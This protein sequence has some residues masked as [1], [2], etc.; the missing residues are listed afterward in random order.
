MTT[1]E[2]ARRYDLRL[3]AAYVRGT[4]GRAD[5]RDLDAMDADSLERIARAGLDAGLRLHPFKLDADLPRVVRAAGVLRGVRPTSLL[6]LGCGRG[7]ALW[8]LVSL[9][10]GCPVLAVDLRVDCLKAVAAVRRGGVRSVAAARMDATALALGDDAMDVVL[11][12]EVLEHVRDVASAV[13]EAARVARRFVVLSVP[14][15]EDDN[16]D[17]LHLLDRARLARLFAEAGVA[18]PLSF[19][20]VHSHLIGVVNVAPAERAGGP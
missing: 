12:L 13:R 7:A 8:P 15:R 17:H 6:E 18:R 9:L 4:L 3:A 1:T 11:A 19:E 20:Q 14:S 16:P 2:L 5:G 10:G